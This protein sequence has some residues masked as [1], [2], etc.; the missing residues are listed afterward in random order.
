MKVIN[1]LFNRIDKCPFDL[2][3]AAFNSQLQEINT[4]LD[5]QWLI[6]FSLV[7]HWTLRIHSSPLKWKDF[8]SCWETLFWWFLYSREISTSFWVGTFSSRYWHTLKL[9][10]FSLSQLSEVLVDTRKANAYPLVDRLVHL[11]L[12]PMWVHVQQ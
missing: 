11:V 5:E 3:S 8:P 10:L 9:Q 4:S 1:A 6:Y 7:Q 12:I 2:F